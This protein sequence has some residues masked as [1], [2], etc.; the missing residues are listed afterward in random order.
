MYQRKE[1]NWDPSV[2]QRLILS[3]RHNGSGRP[4]LCPTPRAAMAT[5]PQKPQQHFQCPSLTQRTP[6]PPAAAQCGW[7][8]INY[9][10]IQTLR[11]LLHTNRGLS[12]KSVSGLSG[13]HWWPAF[14][15]LLTEHNQ[16]LASS[17]SALLT[18]SAVG[19]GPQGPGALGHRDEWEAKNKVGENSESNTSCRQGSK[20]CQMSALCS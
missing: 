8:W 17:A 7:D 1:N 20:R 9:S 2:H 3:G 18:T 13:S 11:S 14:W 19:R 12:S 4:N 6:P 5:A 16:I 15:W 10:Y